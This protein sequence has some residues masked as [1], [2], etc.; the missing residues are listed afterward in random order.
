MSISLFY[1]SFWAIMRGSNFV[2]PSA[3][4][5]GYVIIWLFI[6]GWAV[7]VAV[8]VAEDRLRVGAGY[9]F[10]FFES[11]VF[12]ATLITLFELF[13][14]P[15]KTAW[16]QQVREDHEARDRLRGMNH[17]DCLPPRVSS[18]SAPA[19][20]LSG[21]ASASTPPSA[22]SA[23][24]SAPPKQGDDEEADGSD[25]DAA[26]VNEQT[27]L[28][29]GNATD[30]HMRTTFATTYRRSISALVNGARNAVRN[31]GYE[32]FEY[33]QPWSGHLPSWLWF[34]QFLILG[35]FTIILAAQT[36]LLLTD[37]THQTGAD[38]SNPLLPYLIIFFFTVLLLLPLTPFIH[39]I[40]H[41]IPNFLLVVF[42]ASLIYNLVMFPFSAENRYKAFFLQ[43]IDLDTS[44]N[45]VC[46]S[47]IE[48]YVRPIIAEMP[49]ASGRDVTCGTG[50]RPDLTTCCY[51]GS[52][53]APRLDDDLPDGIP[54][55]VGYAHLLSIN[56]TRNAGNS[57][58]LEVNAT[59]T[60]ACFLEFKRPVSSIAVQG[61][62][63]WDDRFGVY[64]EGGIGLIKLWRR[65][66]SRGWVVDVEWKDYDDEPTS[67]HDGS[68]GDGAALGD[69]ELRRR[70]SGL[71]G[72]VK[73]I[74]SDANTP[75]TI[76]ALDE[77]LK[78]SPRWVAITKTSEG[79]VEGR[80]SFMV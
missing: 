35:P 51:D 68:D 18:M 61:S 42:V 50:R 47:G 75:N 33:E 25:S 54:A 19:T 38:G 24:V 8:T 28:I 27:P 70:D 34:F 60:K 73:C 32:P 3:L 76:P 59:N 71:D 53:V 56:V 29:G 21:D 67:H 62:S 69:G 63:G 17:A 15:K 5:R 31:D 48:R 43:T 26:A 45:K 16:G 30:E 52:E 9:M 12:L 13:A 72:H 58:R 2:R 4:H 80:K 20:A 10:V 49:S 23:S 57:A 64:P 55:E 7:L 77:G 41:H 6:L 44:E 65:D 11:A 40:T 37:A 14:L 22:G 1:F 36:G 39:R 78:F 79:L 46:Y 74:W 66:Y